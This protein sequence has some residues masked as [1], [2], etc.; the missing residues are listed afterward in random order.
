MDMEAQVRYCGDVLS[1]MAECFAKSTLKCERDAPKAPASLGSNK[2]GSDAA[3][4]Q[5]ER[6]TERGA[7]GGKAGQP[8]YG[9]SKKFP[10]IDE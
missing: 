8:G 6:D 10:Y 5:S 9:A 7:S 2:E 3:E 4:S 1:W